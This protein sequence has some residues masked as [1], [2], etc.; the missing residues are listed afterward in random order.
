MLRNM[1]CPRDPRCLFVFN[2]EKWCGRIELRAKSHTDA[3]PIVE[4]KRFCYVK[5]REQH[6]F[7]QKIYI[8]ISNM[9]KMNAIKSHHNCAH[10]KRSISNSLVAR[11][12]VV[13]TES[14]MWDVVAN[15]EDALT[16]LANAKTCATYN[17][18]TLGRH[19]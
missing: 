3:R 4:K 1:L 6:R 10:W 16:V 7:T 5:W 19:F 15:T 12:D 2:R 8:Y 18:L 14:W 17:E 11:S 13:A 9:K